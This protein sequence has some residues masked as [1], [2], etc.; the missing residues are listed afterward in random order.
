[1]TEQIEVR[2]TTITVRV[3]SPRVS[4]TEHTA[5]AGFPGPPLHVHPRFDEVFVVLE[6]TLTLRVGEELSEVGPEGTAFVEG[7]TPHTFMNQS[8]A[9]VRFRAVMAPG[10]FE[11]YF[12]AMAAEDDER[13]AAV[14]ERFGYRPVD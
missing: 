3:A 7:A 13:L 10:G 11:D 12:R 1:M 2:G 14:S 5:P 4:M 8:D 9:P 6:G